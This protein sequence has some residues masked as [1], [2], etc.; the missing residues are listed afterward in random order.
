MNPSKLLQP[1]PVL[2]Q[3]KHEAATPHELQL[4][5]MAHLD[6]CLLLLL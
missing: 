1:V 4:M 2:R 3:L 5:T 6:C